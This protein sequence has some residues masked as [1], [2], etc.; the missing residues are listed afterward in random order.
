MQTQPFDPWSPHAS[1]LR[2]KAL[3]HLFLG[4]LTRSLL[5]AGR[6]CEVLRAEF[7]GSGYD[8]ALE[9]DGIIRH[10]QL[11]AM[12]ADGKRAHVDVHV[13]LAAK[14]S[15]CVIWMLIDP[16]TFATSGYLW[17]G[18]EPGHPL[19]PLGDRAGRHAKADS[20]GRKAERPR[21]R[22][23]AR[24]SFSSLETMDE[25]VLRLFGDER[26]RDLLKLRRH[27]A[28]QPSPPASAPDWL[29]IVRAGIFD[30]MPV[31]PADEELVEFAH[32]VDGY[33]LAGLQRP[34]DIQRALSGRTRR[35][36]GNEMLPSHLWA[37]MFI[38][39]RRLRFGDREPNGE[40]R[41]WLRSAYANLRSAF[42]RTS[43]R[44]AKA[45]DAVTA[46]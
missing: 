22:R 44:M 42:Q 29:R 40:Q 12:R 38:E 36:L 24:G 23:L 14:P 4:D 7:D 6:R 3:E 45:E 39:H 37:A 15:G 28:A 35:P 33:A 13:D 19:P 18:G 20:Q 46:D 27:L 32:L 41:A 16:L 11:K 2:E 5:R 31:G 34:E 21:L 43:G 30:A 8:V 26:Q 17:F 10:V 25:L 9:E 1:V